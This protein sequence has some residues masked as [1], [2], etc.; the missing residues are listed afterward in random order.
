MSE[1][2][3]CHET[4]CPDLCCED[5][6]NRFSLQEVRDVFPDAIHLPWDHEVDELD[7]GVYVLGE[8]GKDG[9]YRVFIRGRCPSNTDGCS[10][11]PKPEFCQGHTFAGSECNEFR[12]EAGLNEIILDTQG[13]LIPQ[14]S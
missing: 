10:A 9:K 3:L 14:P 13:E 12:K 8:K 7:K 2:N 6:W 11:S 4:G 5:K 1:R